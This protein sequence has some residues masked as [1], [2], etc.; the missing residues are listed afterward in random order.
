VA[1]HTGG[2]LSSAL[3]RIKAKT[4]VMP[5]SHDLFFPP[6]ECAADCALIPGAKLCVIQSPEGHMGLN[7][8][9]PHYMAQVDQHLSEL[10]RA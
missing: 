2:D 7:G 8:F 9:E 5:I 3:A 4:Y 6:Q 1:R 10:L